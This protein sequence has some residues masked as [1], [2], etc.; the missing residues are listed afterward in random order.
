MRFGIC[1]GPGSFAPQAQDQPLSA[2]PRL[3]ETLQEAGADYVEFAVGAVSP[4]A[5]DSVFEALRDA[6]QPYPLKVEAF[7]SFI[8]GSHRITGPD[9]DRP[10]VLDYCRTALRRCKALGGQVVVLGSSGARKAPE[11]FDLGRA[12]VQFVEFC[13]ELG[14]VAEEA[15]IDIAIEP[16]NR[17]E[18][19]L[20]LSV[21]HGV[22]LVDEINHPRIRLLADLY[23]MSE[24]KEPLNHVAAAGGLLVHTHCADLGREAPGFASSGEED[25]TGFFRNLRL[26]GYDRRCSFEGQ[27]VD[28]EQ[29]SKPL[30]ELIRRRWNESAG[31]M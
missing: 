24:E 29:Q 17:N 31:G 6:M 8:P 14:P 15:D 10:R 7:N 2:I 23:H 20:V 27:F 12:E 13:R 21:E 4:L 9:V 22:R 11:G 5:P 30:V 3:M 26:A 28:I 18:D 25:F 1:C 19:N 16:L